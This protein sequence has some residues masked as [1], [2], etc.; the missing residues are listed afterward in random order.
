MEAKQTPN[1]FALSCMSGGTHDFV[2]I[3]TVKNGHLKRSGETWDDG[4]TIE[5]IGKFKKIKPLDYQP[6]FNNILEIG[7]LDICGSQRNYDFLGSG[8]KWIDLVSY[9]KK[10]TGLDL[11]EG[12]GVDVIGNSHNMPF[13][14]D[15][16]DLILCLNMLEHDDNAKK[17]LSEARRVLQKGKPFILTFANEKHGEHKDL[18][19]GS[20]YYQNINKNKIYNFMNSAGFHNFEYMEE[21]GDTYIYA[22]K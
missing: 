19:G 14:D 6:K 9:T 13:E 16:F 22:V 4:W 1:L 10:Y 20:D 8:E 7:S 12:R 15:V 3:Y 17:T 21:G 18:G 2:V 11:V 5:K